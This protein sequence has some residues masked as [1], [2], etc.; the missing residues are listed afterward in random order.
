[1]ALIRAVERFDPSVG[2]QFSTF[3]TPTIIGEIKRYFRDTAWA[4][5][6]PRRLKEISQS[7]PYAKEAFIEKYHKVPTPVEL[8]DEM[9]VREEDIL[10]ALEGGKAYSTY[11]LDADTDENSER[12]PISF[13]KYVGDEEKG[14]DEVDTV[15]VLAKLMDGMSEREKAIIRKR[16][17]GDLTQRDV[18]AALGL[19]QMTVSRLEKAMKN[20]FKQA[21]GG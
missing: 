18:A 2:A 7:I 12:E 8:A 10:E 20:K 15:A 9:G 14:Y 17:G 5:K 1:V 19:S 21:Y 3:A 11:S 13:E 6:V 16:L 4:L